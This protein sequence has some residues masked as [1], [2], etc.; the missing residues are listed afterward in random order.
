MQRV[1]TDGGGNGIATQVVAGLIGGLVGSFVMERFQRAVGEWASP[2]AGGE[3]GGGGQQH[4]SPQSEPTT[5]RAADAVSKAT[6]GHKIPREYKPAAG[7]AVHYAFGGSVGAIY[8][9]TAVRNPDVTAWAGVP[10][11]AAVWLIADE[12]GVPLTGLSKPPTE[13]PLKDHASA[14]AAHLLYG[15]A[16]EG[17]R[18]LI[19]RSLRH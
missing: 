19:V 8:G 6:T 5:Y 18:R 11:G 15:A 4:R 1:R 7:A 17:V 9:A 10:F 12:M 13:Y 16:T 2:D 14:L 3:P